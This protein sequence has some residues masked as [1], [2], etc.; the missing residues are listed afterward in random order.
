MEV[1]WM[2]IIGF[3]IGLIARFI[4]PGAQD[5]GIILTTLLGIGGSFLGG[6]IGRAV[7][8]YGANQPAGFILSVIGAVLLLFIGQAI[9]KSKMIERH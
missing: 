7:G 5:M 8:I 9:R 2:L 6:A 4:K 3:V 1:L